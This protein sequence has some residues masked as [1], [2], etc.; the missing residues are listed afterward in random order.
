MKAK[1]R[2]A[3][4]SAILIVALIVSAIDAVK[5]LSNNVGTEQYTAQAQKIF[6]EAKTKIEQIRNVALTSDITLHVITKQQAVDMWGHP[7][8][9]QDRTN[10]DRQE[11]IY[12]GLF[13]MPQGDSL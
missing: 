8:G 11:R 7:S 12:K 2:I 6:E 5:L 4:F 9:T 3:I 1:I 10:I 13:M